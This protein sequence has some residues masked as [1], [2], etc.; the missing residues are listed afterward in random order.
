LCSGGP[1]RVSSRLR[2]DQRN[3]KLMD[4]LR[5]LDTSRS[6]QRREIRATR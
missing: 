2:R 4:S 1:G 3:S 5:E 6:G